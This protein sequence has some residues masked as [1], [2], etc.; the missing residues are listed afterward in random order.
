MEISE[1]KHFIES[2]LETLENGN[3]WIVVNKTKT[4]VILSKRNKMI[5]N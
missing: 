2:V 3:S 1:K 4:I 5:V